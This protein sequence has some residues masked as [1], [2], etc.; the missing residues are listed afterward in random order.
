MTRLLRLT[1]VFSGS[2]AVCRDGARVCRAVVAGRSSVSVVMGVAAHMRG[3]ADDGRE[4]ER[5][6]E[7]ARKE[8]R[9]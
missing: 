4:D 5:Q 9:R 6:A 2:V 7:Y 1:A 8:P 3:S